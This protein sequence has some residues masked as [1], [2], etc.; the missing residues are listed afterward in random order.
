MSYQR[1]C[2][3]DRR[4]PRATPLS[5]ERRRPRRGARAR[6]GRRRSS[7]S[8]TSARTPRSPLSEGDVDG[9]TIECWLHGS[10][11][12]LR[13]GKPTGLPATDR[14]PS[15]PSKIDGDDVLVDLDTPNGSQLTWQRSRSSDLHVTVDTEDG[16]KEILNGVD[17]TISAGETHAIMG[18]NGSG[19]STLAYSIAGH[20]KYKITS[21]IGHPRRRRRAGDDGRR[22]GPRRAVPGDAVPGRGARRLGRQLPAHREDRDRRRGAEAAHLGQGRQRG[23]GA[24]SRWTRPSPSAT[25]TRASPAAR[26]SATRSSS[27]SCSNPK[28]AILDE[29]DSG[30]DIDALKIVSEGVNRFTRERRHGRAA[31]HPLHPD[32]ALHQARLRAR[33]RRRPDRRGGRPGAGRPARGRGLRQVRLRGGELDPT[34][35]VEQRASSERVETI[36]EGRYGH[37]RPG[38]A[39][40][41]GSRWSARTSRSWSARSPAGCRWSTSTAPTPRRSRR[42]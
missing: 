41:T 4:S 37:E 22:A 38:R 31:D 10:R 25:S 2:A 9:C 36:H 20:P 8:R 15:I 18:P 6:R 30:L 33:V 35:S 3:L 7:R 12:D 42:W 21:G 13:T 32:P 39:A 17:L 29:T 1:A 14:S 24:R 34:R 40:A 23:H 11:F 26:R 27:S 28:V 5:V 16:P 19:K